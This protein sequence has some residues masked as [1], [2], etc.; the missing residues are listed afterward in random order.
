MRDFDW[1]ILTTLYKT[2]N[3]TR[4]ANLMFITQPSLTRRLQ[5]IELELN[6]ALTVRSTK[7]VV[8]TPNGEYVAQK[9]SEILQT[10][11][12]IK[13]HIENSDQGTQ[14]TLRIGVPNSFMHFVVP[15]LLQKFSEA[16]PQVKLELYT[17]LSSQL[18]KSLEEQELHV[19]F[20]RG[21]ISTPLKKHLLSEDQIVIIS[22]EPIILENLPNLARIEYAKEETII[23]ATS[24]WWDE[25]FSV[26]PNIKLKVNSGEACLQMIK[27]KLGYGIFSDAKYFDPMDGL[28]T[29]P[30]TFKDDSKFTRKSWLAYDEKVLHYPLVANFISFALQSFS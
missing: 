28:Y 25:H 1:K 23:E 8:F 2:R 27:H 6:T 9:A 14:G 11:D 22:H 16:Y 29:L 26:P 12:E 5:Q 13:N 30:L 21:N 3:I 7:G 10:L 17:D 4:T 20:A 19:C 18:I 15:S 24:K